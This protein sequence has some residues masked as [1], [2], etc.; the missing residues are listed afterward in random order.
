M[1]WVPGR[2]ES[3]IDR[4][5]VKFLLVNLHENFVIFAIQS[6]NERN[7]WKC[8]QKDNIFPKAA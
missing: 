6:I 7:Y 8:D 4:V 3:Y 5:S 2:V 1:A